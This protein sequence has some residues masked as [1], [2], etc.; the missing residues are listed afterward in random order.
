MTGGHFVAEIL[1]NRGLE[2]GWASLGSLL[3]RLAG[4]LWRPGGILGEP[5]AIL[6]C[7]GAVLGHLRRSWRTLGA[8][9]GTA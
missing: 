4:L 8:V 1:E 2:G 3:G 5:E 6:G 9:L 7:L